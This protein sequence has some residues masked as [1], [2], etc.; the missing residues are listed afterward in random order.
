MP[1]LVSKLY[2]NCIKLWTKLQYAE[3]GEGY[4]AVS[5]NKKNPQH[6]HAKSLEV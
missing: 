3:K 1:V 6:I 4:A 5:N 2:W